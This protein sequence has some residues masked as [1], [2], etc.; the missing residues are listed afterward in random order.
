MHALRQ[1]HPHH[2]G[3]APGAGADG[4]GHDILGRIAAFGP[5]PRGGTPPVG[6]WPWATAS[7][8]RSS[9]AAAGASPAGRRCPRNA[10]ARSSTATRPWPPAA[11]SPA[12]WRSIACWAGHGDLPR[13]GSA[14]GR[15]RM[16]RQLR[17][18]HG[19]RG[20]RGRRRPG[21]PIGPHH[22]LRDAGRDG[23]RL[24]RTLG[25]SAVIA[26]DLDP[27]R[28]ALARTFGARTPSRPMSCRLRV[29]GDRRPRRRRGDRA[30]RFAR[31]VRGDLPP[32]P[33]R[34][35]AH[36]RGVDV[37]F[38]SGP[39][40]MEHVVRR[41][42]TL[43][44]LHNYALYISRLRSSSRRPPRVPVPIAGADWQPRT[45]RRGRRE[46]ARA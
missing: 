45:R 43:R 24:G 32:G 17:D 28:R 5:T 29:G 21:R 35:H 22:G 9:R 46:G 8:G 37:S 41:C 18:G 42:L 6:R 14:P 10:N 30:D 2:S 31:R 44:G 1:R 25:C 15:D 11:S 34:R 39:L 19:G 33:A 23:R 27:A 7:P 13:A 38:P 16:S 26:C 3:T 4:P 40:T 12:G 20:D 36:P